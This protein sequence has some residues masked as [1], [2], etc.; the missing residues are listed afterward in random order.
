MIERMPGGGREPAMPIRRSLTNIELRLVQRV[1]DVFLK[2]LKDTWKKVV[3][4]DFT[5][6]QTES[7]PQ[8]IQSIE[9][10]EE[11]IVLCIEVSVAEIRGCMTLCI[12]VNVLKRLHS[13]SQ[14]DHEDVV[15]EV[16]RKTSGVNKP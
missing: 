9:P 15:M 12:P 16:F 1:I 11:V 14:S 10:N 6:E 13:V 8:F 4:L 2:E 7:D 5:V 3:E